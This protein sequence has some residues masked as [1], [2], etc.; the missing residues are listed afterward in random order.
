MEDALDAQPQSPDN[1]LDQVRDLLEH[2][3]DLTHLQQHPFA[4]AWMQV[5]TQPGEVEALQVRRALIEAI[6]STNP[7]SNFYF[8]APQ[9]RPYQ[10]LQL[11]YVERLTIQKSAQELGVSERQAYRDLRQGEENI[12]TYLR[13]REAQKPPAASEAS[14]PQRGENLAVLVQGAITSVEKL[15]L[16]K[17]VAIDA[18]LSSKIFMAPVESTIAR[19]VLVSLISRAIQQA[20][21]SLR[22]DLETGDD[23]AR[24]VLA[25][26]PRSRDAA[27]LIDPLVHGFVQQMGWELKDEAGPT[28]Q[29]TLV[30]P[31]PG[32]HLL[33][34]D[35]DEGFTALVRRYLT[36]FALQTSVA[37]NGV[38]GVRAAQLEHPNVIL[39]DVMMPGLDGW[40]VL[41]TLRT[42][43]RTM[44][45]P[46]I[47]CS[48]FNDPELARS[49]GA[50]L[51]LPKPASQESL[52]AAL[53]QA[54][55]L[56]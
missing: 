36:G 8:R 24:L 3:Y 13:T 9:A 50:T 16:Q 26:T 53:R 32:R 15:A 37:R 49:L 44:Q 6:E 47:V 46:V 40:Q 22:L 21:G 25:F 23:P 18:H 35:D 4:R 5:Q 52:L 48:V 17:E 12:L 20:R 27:S 7:G 31:G 29:V 45:V 51:L 2:L 41:Q 28:R 42:D 19:Q 1:S 38:D 33:M 34:I 10:M 56:P 11:H 30:M 14:L 54:G 39:L 43:P 55:L